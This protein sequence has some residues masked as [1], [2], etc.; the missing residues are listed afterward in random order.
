MNEPQ[1]AITQ[2]TAADLWPSAPAWAAGFRAN[3]EP[4]GRLFLRGEVGGADG[5]HVFIQP[6]AW[7]SKSITGAPTK[8]PDS[9][10]INYGLQLPQMQAAA[11]QV[12]TNDPEFGRQ[13]M[14]STTECRPSPPT[15]PELAT[16][17]LL[18]PAILLASAFIVGVGI[19]AAALLARSRRSPR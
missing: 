17:P 3:V 15:A 12:R 13:L 19:V 1:A 9:G 16:S 8:G 5:A 4:D 11:G 18:V 6:K 2:A 14:A 7:A 10:A